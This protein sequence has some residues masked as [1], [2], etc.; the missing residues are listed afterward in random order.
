MSKILR[1][2]PLLLFSLSLLFSDFCRGQADQNITLSGIVL[3]LDSLT[4]IPSA[5]IYIH[6]SNRGVRSN[7]LGLFS[8][9]VNKGDTMVFSAI[10]SKTT[11]FVVP[12]SLALNSYSII[13][14]MPRDT[15]HL[16][17]VEISSWPS[18]EEFNRAF[19]EKFGYESYEG[20]EE[21]SN[22]QKVF[23]NM[24]PEDVNNFKREMNYHSGD[25]SQVYE[26]A[27][28][29]LKDVLNPGRWDKLVKNWKEGKHN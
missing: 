7:A 17:M 21:N 15:I 26:N 6:G 14:R 23:K 24:S 13:Q 28:I 1:I 11:Y 9:S 22:P 8:L 29:P 2:T 5:N 4:P 16:D 27:H 20:A 3:R 18:I 19:T 25:Y 10:G 12:D